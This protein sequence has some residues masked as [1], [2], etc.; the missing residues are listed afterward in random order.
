MADQWA[1]VKMTVGQLSGYV[2]D[3]MQVNDKLKM[4]FGLRLDK[5]MYNNMF[6]YH[7]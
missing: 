7:S 2:Q 4:T 3:E 5:P 1:L 6:I